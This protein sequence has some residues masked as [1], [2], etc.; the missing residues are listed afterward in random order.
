MCAVHADTYTQTRECV[1]K[2]DV[3]IKSDLPYFVITF[4]VFPI[5]VFC[6]LICFLELNV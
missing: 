6:Y 3:K 4:I 2:Y 1:E 5:Y